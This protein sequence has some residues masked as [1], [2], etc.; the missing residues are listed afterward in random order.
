MNNIKYIEP[1][2]SLM[3]RIFRFF[4]I[5]LNTKFNDGYFHTF[6]YSGK[7]KNNKRDII[8]IEKLDG[9]VISIPNNKKYYTFQNNF[10]YSGHIKNIE[11]TIDNKHNTL[12]LNEKIS[13]NWDA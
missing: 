8:I 6:G 9:N 5:E 7:Q 10:I 2:K 3:G 4:G 1:N 11:K 13:V 12:F